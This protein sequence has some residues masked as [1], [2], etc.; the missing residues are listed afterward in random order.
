MKKELF[1]KTLV[2]GVTFLFIGI[3]FSVS[4]TTGSNSQISGA[5]V[6][7]VQNNNE[8]LGNC[9]LDISYDYF[10]DIEI[11]TIT[12]PC[13]DGP[14]KTYPVQT[15]IKNIG[16]STECCFMKI[17]GIMFH[18]LDGMMNIKILPMIMVGI[19]LIL[20]ILGEIHLRQFSDI[21]RHYLII[22]FIPMQLIHQTIQVVKWS[23]NHI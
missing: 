18:L 17:L 9:P 8:I 10:H 4:P 1:I 16:Q 14:G 19:N 22:Y 23:S 11:T 12:T 5:G 13:E 3:I 21:T 7:G 15:T 6:A 2:M 20:L